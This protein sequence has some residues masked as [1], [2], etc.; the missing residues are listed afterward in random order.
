MSFKYPASTEAFKELLGQQRVKRGTPVIEQ[1]VD[2]NGIRLGEGRRP[3]FALEKTETTVVGAAGSIIESAI[4]VTG[5]CIVSNAMLHC[6]ANT[7]AVTVESG[8]YCILS[9]C[10]IT[11]KAGIQ[12]ATDRY[13]HV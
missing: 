11:K 9:G 3:G 8:G 2:E 4:T 1:Q 6:D 10:H 5:T 7:P 13:V 12:G